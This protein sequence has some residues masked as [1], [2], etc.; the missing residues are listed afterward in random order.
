MPDVAAAGQEGT[1]VID[2][3][4]VRG[5]IRR[6]LADNKGGLL[7]LGAATSLLQIV[8]LAVP[9]ATRVL[10]DQMQTSYVASRVTSLAVGLVAI[11]VFRAV[12]GFSRGR[13]VLYLESRVDLVLGRTFFERLFAL[14]FALLGRKTLGEL[15][16]G[17]SAL[18][19]LRDAATNRILGAVLDATMALLLP[20]AMLVIYPAATFVVIAAA[21]AVAMI[22]VAVGRRQAR[23]QRHEI[24][25][26]NEQRSIVV[27]AVH[28]IATIKTASAEQHLIRRWKER[29]ATELW[30]GL[31]RQ[32]IGITSEIAS[33]LLV[34]GLAAGVLCFGALLAYEGRLSIGSL[35]A[36][37]QL[38]LAFLTAVSSLAY[39][40]LA[41][42]VLRPQLDPVREV[43]AATPAAPPR[44]EHASRLPGTLVLDRVW[45]RYGDDLPW[46]H[47]DYSLRLDPGERRAITAPSG[48]GKTTILRLVAGLYAPH[49]GSVR[50][51]GCDAPPAAFAFYMPQAI[52]L[53]SGS[54]LQNLRLLSGDAPPE[55]I[56]EAAEETGLA[57]L[58]ATL[59]MGYDTII[60]PGGGSFSGGQRQLIALTAAVASDRPLLL[61]DEPASNLDAATRA[62][63][64]GIPSLA[65]KTIL[66]AAHE[67][68]L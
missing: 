8:A 44:R 26:Q 46:V 39:A 19:L 5:V 14:P 33:E 30:H 11:A 18:A 38:M 35:I 53:Y 37:S 24:V 42:A 65:A 1:E 68:T 58:I 16:Q 28:G 66:Y 15:L 21:L 3:T 51:D 23:E 56:F 62:R 59:P 43:L 32:R 48:F 17:F 61:L 47:R 9:L 12:I 41:A 29:F 63:L 20:I 34:S 27:E 7:A 55:R 6:L 25:A 10:L 4:N 45:F 60:L 52:Q 57:S 40:Y 54:I 67:A 36:F 64:T 31:R 49:S 50:I 13:L 2:A 22:T